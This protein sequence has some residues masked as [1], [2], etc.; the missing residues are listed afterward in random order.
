M[1]QKQKLVNKETNSPK[2]VSIAENGKSEHLIINPG[3]IK[4]QQSQKKEAGRPK[5]STNAAGIPRKAPATTFSQKSLYEKKKQIFKTLTPDFNCTN[6]LTEE[7]LVKK[8]DLPQRW[9]SLPKELADM[10]IGLLKKHFQKDAFSHLQ[11]LV[12]ELKRNTKIE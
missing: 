9:D 12:K 5:I 6:V 2:F 3:V 1:F 4:M 10:D 8:S 11:K 7:Y